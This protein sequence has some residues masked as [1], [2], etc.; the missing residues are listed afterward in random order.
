MV[1]Y[2][3]IRFRSVSSIAAPVATRALA[4]ATTGMIV[5]QL[6]STTKLAIN[7]LAKT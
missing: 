1:L 5:C 2:A 3:I 6:S 4:P 7:N